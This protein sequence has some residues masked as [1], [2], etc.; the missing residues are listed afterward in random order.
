[1]VFYRSNPAY[2]AAPAPS[3]APSP[4]LSPVGAPA[5]SPSPAPALSPDLAPA[6]DTAPAPACSFLQSCRKLESRRTSLKN[7]SSSINNW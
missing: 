6:H 5:P 2:D 3:P 7:K 1:M 4:A